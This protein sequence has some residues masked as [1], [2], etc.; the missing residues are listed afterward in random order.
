MGISD[1]FWPQAVHTAAHILNRALLINNSD[2]TPYELWKERL[3]NINYFRVFRSKC[4]IKR[5]DKVGK[6]DSRVDEGIL[7]GYS[8]KSKAYKCYNHRLNKVVESINVII[9]DYPQKE[10]KQR[11]E[12][13]TDDESAEIEQPFEVEYLSEEPRGQE[14]QQEFHSSQTPSKS[15]WP[16]SKTPTRYVQKNHPADQIIGDSSVGVGTRRRNQLQSPSQ[17][18]KSL[19]S[20]IEP[21]N[22]EQPLKINVGSRPWKKN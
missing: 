19:I 17:E 16:S 6:F 4:Y 14:S 10:E 22:Y 7:L 20:T 2:K 1:K 9:D 3:A 13:I 18:H 5:E 21:S 15:P 8:S 12:V 11:K